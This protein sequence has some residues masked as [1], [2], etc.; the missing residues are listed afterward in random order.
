M[1][2]FRKP[3]LKCTEPKPPLPRRE[4]LE[5]PN[6]WI[7]PLSAAVSALSIM[8]VW[9]MNYLNPFKYVL[10]FQDTLALSVC[11]AWAWM[12]FIPRIY[13]WV[14]P[15]IHF[16]KKA[17]IRQSGSGNVGLKYSQITSYNWGVG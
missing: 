7:M 15:T 4:D 1:A 2:L 9:G 12:T 6:Y 13:A 5:A 8:T 16:G 14:P 11:V 3:L 10:P 17:V